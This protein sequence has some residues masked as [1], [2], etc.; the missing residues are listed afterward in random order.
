MTFE[1]KIPTYTMDFYSFCKV[2]VPFLIGVAITDLG[3]LCY[4]EIKRI[5]LQKENAKIFRVFVDALKSYEE[6]MEGKRC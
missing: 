4:K 1:K 2:A 3:H 6:L 5:R